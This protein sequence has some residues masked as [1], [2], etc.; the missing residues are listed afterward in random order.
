MEAY[1]YIT[2]VDEQG[3]IKV[4]NIPQMKSSKV[5]I[6]ILPIQ[7][8]DFSDLLEASESSLGFWDNP[9]DEEWNHV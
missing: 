9:I 7:T 2:D 4:P 6:I 8:D 3:R 5:E 1:K